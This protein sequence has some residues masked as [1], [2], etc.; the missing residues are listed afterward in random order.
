VLYTSAI[1]DRRSHHQSL[2]E[3]R[4]PLV[5][6]TDAEATKSVGLAER[7]AGKGQPAGRRLLGQRALST[8]INL[9]EEGL[10]AEYDSPSAKDVPERSRT[11]ASWA[12]NG[13]RG[14]GDGGFAISSLIRAA[15]KI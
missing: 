5:L 8:T 3:R 9:A 11:R 15:W 2:R 13:L 7:I 6:V 1:T 10:L 14:P 12:G 4:H